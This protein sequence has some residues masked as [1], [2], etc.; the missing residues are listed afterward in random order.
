MHALRHTS[1]PAQTR[2]KGKGGDGE[3]G[4]EP[5][6]K[7]CCRALTSNDPKHQPGECRD[8]QTFRYRVDDTFGAELSQ[9]FYAT[10]FLSLR[11]LRS[12]ICLSRLSSSGSMPRSSRILRASCSC[13]FSKKRLTKWRISDR[14]ASCRSIRGTYTCARP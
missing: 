6:T 5:Y 8:Q 9:D 10:H 11:L 1:R 3:Q 12:S 13:E 4:N 7:P 14:V 2:N